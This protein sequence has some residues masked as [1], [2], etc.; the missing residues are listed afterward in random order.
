MGNFTSIA[1]PEVV[2]CEWPS[3]EDED[4]MHPQAIAVEPQALL[5]VF[6]TCHQ[7]VQ[8]VLGG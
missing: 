1:W 8:A 5:G 6:N 3:V 2:D 7:M 4:N